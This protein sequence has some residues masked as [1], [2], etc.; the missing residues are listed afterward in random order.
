MDNNTEGSMSES[1]VEKEK[2]TAQY[3]V[4]NDDIAATSYAQGQYS[5]SNCIDVLKILKD[6]KNYIPDEDFC[7]AFELIKDSKNRII[8]ISLK[9]RV[10]ILTIW[11][12][13]MYIK[14]N[15]GAWYVGGLRH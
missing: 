6:S 15:Y 1:H 3:V 8:V 2:K 14:K 9:D 12:K 10:D 4:E 5:I 7:Y 11:I 13:N